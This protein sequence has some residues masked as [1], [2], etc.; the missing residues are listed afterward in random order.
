MARLGA[1][2]SSAEPELP[3]PPGGRTLAVFHLAETS[4]PSVSLRDT[5]AW[6]AGAAP[7]DVLVPGPG[8]V[9]EDFGAFAEVTVLDYDRVTLPGGPVSAAR[10]AWRLGRDFRALRGHIRATRPARVIAV[11]ATLPTALLAA[12]AER[13]PALLYA[14]EVLPRGPGVRRRAGGR[15][16]TRLNRKL[17]D[18]IVSCSEVVAREFAGRRALPAATVHP[19]IGPEYQGGDGA[20]LRRRHGIDPGARC[21]A[22]VGAISVGRGHDVLMRALPALLGRF[23]D[24]RTLLVGAPHPGP[25]DLSYMEGVMALARRLGVEDSLVWTGFVEDVADVYAAADAVVNPARREAFGRVAAEALMAGCPVVSTSAEAIPE[26]LRD[27]VDALLVGP[28][29]PD[30]LAAALIRV[31]EDGALAAALV[32]AGRARVRSEFSLQRSLEGFASVL[33]AA[34]PGPAPADDQSR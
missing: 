12:R 32:A 30:A 1:L 4:G 13:V 18:G 15:L 9:A 31:L 8:R 11:T 33:I 14:A 26:V 10:S 25:A 29:S 6:L 19:P 22:L 2:R 24:L 17:A 23:P 16:L 28:E 27:G 7:V 21:I 3:S 34:A 5:L 20:A